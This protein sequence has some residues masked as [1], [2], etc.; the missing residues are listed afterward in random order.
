MSHFHPTLRKAGVPFQQ[1]HHGIVWPIHKERQLRSLM[2][3]KRSVGQN[4]LDRWGEVSRRMQEATSIRLF[5]DFDG[6][7]VDFRTR[8]NQVR[9][10]AGTRL[11][12]RKLVRHRS[13]RIAIVSGRRRATVRRLVGIA[14]LQYMGLYG[15]ED[16]AGRR[17]GQTALRQLS[18]LRSA[19]S[20][21]PKELPGIYLEDKRFSMAIHFRGL[22]TRAQRAAR[23]RTRRILAPF[24]RTLSV[25]RGD[26]IWEVVPRQ[27]RGKGAAIR[28]E[29]ATAASPLL[30]IYIGDDLTDE[31]AF[32]VLRNGITVLVGA[33]RPTKARFRLRSPD[34]VR[35]FLTRF[36]AELP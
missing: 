35:M 36:E 22:S 29:L 5:L 18:R 25:I 27:I 23:I 4:L 12:L 20:G 17:P 3:R 14:G 31:P 33:D 15:W 28:K 21:L 30:P 6:T 16:R 11:A 24:R 19:L 1:G 32:A 26:H 9:L 7:L 34:E 8:P 13:L 2:A 10:S